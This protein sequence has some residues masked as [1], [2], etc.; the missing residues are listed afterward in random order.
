[1]TQRERLHGKLREIEN[2][3]DALNDERLQV[4][5]DLMLL[6]DDKQWFE[7]KMESFVRRSKR[8]KETIQHLIGRVYWNENFIDEDTGAVVTINR[9]RVVRQ[10]GEW[11]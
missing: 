1:M 5:R 6:C 8:K 7:E 10:D 3:I 4:K 9:S 11:L 2:Q